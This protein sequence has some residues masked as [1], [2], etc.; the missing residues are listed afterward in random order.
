MGHY[1]IHSEVG[2]TLNVNVTSGIK[3]AFGIN[4]NHYNNKSNLTGTSS[5]AVDKRTPT[6]TVM[7]FDGDVNVKIDRDSHE[8]AENYGIG[9]TSR[10]IKGGRD[11][12]PD[13]SKLEAIFRGN[14]KVDVT[15]V[16]DAQGNPKSI[17]DAIGVDGKNSK[18]EL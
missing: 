13:D 1:H 4:V 15:P 2:S 12:I 9:L 16:Y 10:A 7:E 11:T 17:G 8:K 14:L 5:T 6:V 18:V 3:R